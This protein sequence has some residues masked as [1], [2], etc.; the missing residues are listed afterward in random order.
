MYAPYPINALREMHRVLKPRG[1]CVTA[2]WGK[3]ISCGWAGV[4][5]IVDKRVASDVFPLFFNL[6]N[7]GVLEKTF[8]KAGFL[9][10]HIERISTLLLY[11]SAENACAAAFEGGPVALAYFKFPE[12]VKKEACEEYLASIEQYKN[13]NAYY[14]PGEFVI[15]SGIK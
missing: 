13:G 12:Q 11:P 2:V 6:G 15:G 9:K 10:V 8:E 3:R 5:D 7:E 14:V 1:R 4:F